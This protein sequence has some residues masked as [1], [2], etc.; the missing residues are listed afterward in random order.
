MSSGL[1]KE[2]AQILKE[3]RAAGDYEVRMMRNGHW[4][5]TR[6]DGKGRGVTIAASPGAQITVWRN[7][8]QLRRHLGFVRN[9]KPKLAKTLDNELL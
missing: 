8:S 3:L 9:K 1:K 7:E 4:R 2:V 5:V 6:K